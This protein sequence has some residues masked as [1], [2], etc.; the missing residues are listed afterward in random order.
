[1]AG[2]MCILAAMRTVA[3]RGGTV[4]ALRLS[5]VAAA[6]VAALHLFVFPGVAMAG[7]D[8]A[9]ADHP[10]ISTSLIEMDGWGEHAR[11]AKTMLV[12]VQ[13]AAMLAAAK[14]LG[15]L[16]ERVKIPGVIGELL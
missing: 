3:E 13:I 7:I 4:R 5:V 14:L 8:S 10:R 2:K 11:V 6:V 15:W 16:C 1:M 12:L 9:A